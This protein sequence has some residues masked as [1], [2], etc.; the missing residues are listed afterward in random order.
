MSMYCLTMEEMGIRITV[1]EVEAESQEDAE[2][3]LDVDPQRYV[4]WSRFKNYDT[5]SREWDE[6]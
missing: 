3:L 1:Y 5:N 4:K 6:I 2:D